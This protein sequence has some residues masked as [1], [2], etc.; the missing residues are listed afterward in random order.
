MLLHKS[1]ERNGLL[2][3][4]C[5]FSRGFRFH[6]RLHPRETNGESVTARCLFVYSKSVTN[7]LRFHSRTVKVCGSADDDSCVKNDIKE[8][9]KAS[10]LNRTVCR[11]HRNGFERR[12]K[13]QFRLFR[14]N[15]RGRPS[16]LKCHVGT[17][18]S[19][20]FFDEKRRLFRLTLDIFSF[21]LK[22]LDVSLLSLAWQSVYFHVSK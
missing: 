15:V 22:H 6:R 3:S 10:K 5:G 4:S 16:L 2:V 14:R 21:A 20:R 19:V 18:N 1:D 8:P 17:S 12:E 7:T 11:V 9:L 13:N